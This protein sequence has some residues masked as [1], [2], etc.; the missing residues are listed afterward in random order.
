M[1]NP[2]TISRLDG[3]GSQLFS[4]ISGLAHC[5]KH[6]IKYAHTRISNIKL[7]HSEEF[8]NTEVHRANDFIS[9]IIANFPLTTTEPGKAF[10]HFHMEA[11]NDRHGYYNNKF[12]TTLNECYNSTIINDK[13]TIAIHVRR[14]DDIIESDKQ[15]RWIETDYY[16]KLIKYIL[17]KETDCLIK[18]F[19]W[20]DSGINIKDER[21]EYH[22]SKGKGDIFMDNFLDLVHSDILIVG[23]ST[24][25]ISAGFFNKGKVLCNEKLMKLNQTAIPPIWGDNFNQYFK[26]L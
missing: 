9:P 22:V 24:F 14:G 19:S 16:E 17:K 3:F 5:Y 15:Y 2:I 11:F 4:I 23:S 6:N 13:L 20:N 12:L 10:P 18:I 21:I 7:L 1:N 26:D 8:M 25:S